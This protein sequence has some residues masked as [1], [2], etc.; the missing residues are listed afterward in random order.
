MATTV[1]VGTQAVDRAAQLLV[2]VLESAAPVASAELVAATGL[3]KSTVSR[4]LS[5]LERSGLIQRTSEGAVI[6]GPRITDYAL[7]VRPEDTLVRL[8]QPSL[9]RLSH[10][11]GETV[12]LAIP[13]GGEVRQIAQVD[14][15]YLLGAVNWLDRPVPFHCSALGRVFLAHGHPIPAGR[16]PRLTDRTITSR[17]QLQRAL[18]RVAQLGYAVVD[19]ELEPGLVAVAAPIRSADGSVNAAVSVSGPS[20]RLTPDALPSVGALVVEAADSI[21]RA[22][23]Q[24]RSSTSRKGAA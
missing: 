18:D 12:N 7:S 9:D 21:S 11:T 23:R 24:G 2:A 14:A 22:L 8:A 20:V 17:A 6:A 16:L 10:L 3:P 5:S 15:V 1:P 19:C 13:L 4:L